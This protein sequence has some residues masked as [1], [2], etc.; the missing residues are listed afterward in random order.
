MLQH[1]IVQLLLYYLSS[2]R[3][4][5]LKTKENSTLLRHKETKLPKT[6]QFLVFNPLTKELPVLEN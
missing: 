1:L 5:R 3:L 4:G 2:S 6:S